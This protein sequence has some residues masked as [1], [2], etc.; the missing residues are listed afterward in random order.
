MTKM[1]KKKRTFKIT[2]RIG[3][4]AFSDRLDIKNIFSPEFGNKASNKL[5]DQQFVRTIYESLLYR[6]LIISQEMLEEF[7]KFKFAKAE[8]DFKGLTNKLSLNK[9][10]LIKV[11]HQ[12]YGD[13]INTRYLPLFDQSELFKI[14]FI[15][16]NGSHRLAFNSATPQLINI[17]D[18]F[19]KT[20]L[21]SKLRKKLKKT[22]FDNFKDINVY[23]EERFG[24]NY[25]KLL[26]K[27]YES[28]IS[29]NMEFSAIFLEIH[30]LR[31]GNGYS[32]ENFD[33]E[34][35]VKKILRYK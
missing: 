1:T 21:K 20:E 28:L 14:I 17:L 13:W 23:Y 24:A 9:T 30:S 8:Q 7:L 33:I 6:L 32:T 2:K 25:K 22:M 3:S 4:F 19:G 27:F 15:D 5:T 12:G 35:F 31:K 26:T 10:G 34:L 29:D 16:Y 18:C 11:N